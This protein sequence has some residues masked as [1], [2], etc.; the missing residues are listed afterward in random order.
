M[1]SVRARLGAE[2]KVYKHNNKHQ[3]FI[4]GAASGRLSADLKTLA[5]SRIT[6]C[7]AY[8]TWQLQA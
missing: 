4:A 6:C 3:E 8:Y 1:S 7:T 2:R 5:L